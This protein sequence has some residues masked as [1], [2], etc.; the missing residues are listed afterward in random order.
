MEDFVANAF[1]SARFER[2]IDKQPYYGEIP[3][4]RGVWATGRTLAECKRKLRS[5]L[6]DWVRMR[7]RKGLSLKSP[8]CVPRAGNAKTQANEMA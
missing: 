4:C 5:A 2:I 6:H 1:A 3:Q 8:V 7:E